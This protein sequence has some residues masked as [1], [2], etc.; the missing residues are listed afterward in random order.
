MSVY[1]QQGQ[2]SKSSLM[3]LCKIFVTLG[4]RTEIFLRLNV[5]FDVDVILGWCIKI[6]NYLY[7]MNNY[8]A[9]AFKVTKI[10]QVCLKKL[11]EFWPMFVDVLFNPGLFRNPLPKYDND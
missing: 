6:I 3:Q 4:L 2:D 9:K 5:V 11:W 7:S 8:F 1:Y 10:L